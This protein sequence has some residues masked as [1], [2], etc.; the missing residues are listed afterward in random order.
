MGRGYDAAMQYGWSFLGQPVF[1]VLLV[2]GCLAMVPRA[3]YTAARMSRLRPVDGRAVEP[4]A[5]QRICLFI[6]GFCVFFCLALFGYVTGAIVM[7]VAYLGLYVAMIFW[8]K[9][10]ADRGGRARE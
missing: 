7:L 10:P 5:L 1:W 2:L 4:T 8:F 9:T 3:R 6:P